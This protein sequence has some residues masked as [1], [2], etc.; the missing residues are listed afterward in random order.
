MPLGVRDPD[1]FAEEMKGLMDR[2]GLTLGQMWVRLNHSI[3]KSHLSKMLRGQIPKYQTLLF[4]VSAFPE[5][6]LSD[7]FDAAGYAAP[8]APAIG[9][10]LPSPPGARYVTDEAGTAVPLGPSVS[11]RNLAGGGDLPEETIDFNALILASGGDYVLKV[12]GDCME[13]Q[14]H[15][16]DYVAVRK[17][18][19]APSG[20]AVVAQALENGFTGELGDGFTLKVWRSS[21]PE[22]SGFYRADGSKAMSTLEARI[23][24]RVVGVYRASEPS[25]K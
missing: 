17:A 13:P 24:G 7:L 9:G 5:E 12:V 23:V 25:F 15:R 14:I 18:H 1:R 21:G 16:G 3:D 20:K 22:G 4:F 19:R 10:D 2:K 6:D 11:A 8:G